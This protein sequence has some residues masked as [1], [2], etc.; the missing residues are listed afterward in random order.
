MKAAIILLAFLAPS[1]A[2]VL[3]VSRKTRQMFQ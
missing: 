2:R 1:L 3:P